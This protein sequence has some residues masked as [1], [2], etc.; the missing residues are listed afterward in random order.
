MT[1]RVD[2]GGEVYQ[3][4]LTHEV[5]PGRVV[6][7]HKECALRSIAEYKDAPYRN[8]GAVRLLTLEQLV[9]YAKDRLAACGGGAESALCAFVD[10]GHAKCVFNYYQQ[11]GEL[12][13]GDD[14][15]VYDLKHTP[16]WDVWTRGDGLVLGQAD[17]CEFIE[18]NLKDIVQPTGADMLQMVSDFRQRTQVEYGSSY[19]TSDGQ[20]SLTYQETKTGANKEMALPA[21][22]LLHLPV[23]LGAESITTYEMKA[24]LYVRVDKDSHRLRFVYKL[25]RPDIPEQ[26]AV[27][28]VAE[29]LR[30]ALSGIRVYEGLVQIRAACALNH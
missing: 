7:M 11:G 16:E 18:D 17:F 26:N 4:G 12:G 8:A 1:G 23:V 5:L 24:R 27:H 14:V 28:D 29:A 3:A 30:K 22:M 25:I 9:A 19:R 15:A 2:M 20:Q 13:W 6:A 10:G 21:E